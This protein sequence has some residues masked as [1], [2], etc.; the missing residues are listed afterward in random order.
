MRRSGAGIP[1]GIP[2][3]DSSLF[4]FVDL[5]GLCERLP[6]EVRDVDG[7]DPL[8]HIVPYGAGVAVG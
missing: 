7:D 3:D 8:G 1:M 5:G 4:R 2:Q 6:N